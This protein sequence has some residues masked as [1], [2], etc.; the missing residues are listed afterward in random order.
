MPTSVDVRHGVFKGCH[1]VENPEH[2][3]LSETSQVSWLRDRIVGKKL[4]EIQDKDRWNSIIVRPGFRV[5][6]EKGKPEDM[7][8]FLARMFSRL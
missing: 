8:D 4:H 6:N 1:M 5:K 2:K 7:A 3:G